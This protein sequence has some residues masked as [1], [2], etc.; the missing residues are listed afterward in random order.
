MCFV[1]TRLHSDGSKLSDDVDD[2]ADGER[3]QRAAAL[4]WEWH[5]YNTVC[6]KSLFND[7]MSKNVTPT[8]RKILYSMFALNV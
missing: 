7:K 5:T 6:L 1:V 3:D 8:I 2:A 4:E